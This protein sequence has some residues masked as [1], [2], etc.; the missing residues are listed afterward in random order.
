MKPE[1]YQI[2]VIGKGFLAVMA[3]PVSG[4]WIG[5]EF[6]GIAN[7]GIEQIVSLVSNYDVIFDV[8]TSN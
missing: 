3:K 1:I 6:L 4:E 2:E 7:E 8:R 5:E